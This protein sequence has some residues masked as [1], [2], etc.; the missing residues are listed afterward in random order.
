MSVYLDP[1]LKAYYMADFNYLLQEEKDLYWQLDAGIKA[2]LIAINQNPGLQT[3]YSKL[4]QADKDGFIDP[5]SYLR[6]AFVPD[7]EK[8]VQ[9]ICIELIHALDGRDAQVNVSPEDGL[10][11][12]IYKADS[13]MG[14]KNNPD[15]FRVKHFYIELRSEQEELHRRFWQ[16]LEEKLLALTP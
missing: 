11:N 10:E 5:I 2:C 13:P 9:Q 6:L 15:Y 8:P 16:M 12:R 4:F 14:C 7:L 3:L 1:E